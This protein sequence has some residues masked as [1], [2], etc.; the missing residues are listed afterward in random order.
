MSPPDLDDDMRIEIVTA[1]GA[2]PRLS[3]ALGVWTTRNRFV[4]IGDHPGA[5]PKGWRPRRGAV[6]R[7]NCFDRV[8][9]QASSLLDVNRRSV[10]SFSG[11]SPRAEE[12]RTR[13]YKGSRRDP[14]EFHN[15]PYGNQELHAKGGAR[16][17]LGAPTR[18]TKSVPVL[19]K[20]A[21]CRA[22]GSYAICC[23]HNTGSWSSTA[24]LDIKEG[25]LSL[26]G[27][28]RKSSCAHLSKKALQDFD[29][30]ADKE[31][32]IR[33]ID[34]GDDKDGRRQDVDQRASYNA[35]SISHCPT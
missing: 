23:T 7:R 33:P 6:W 16:L 24:T 29:Q 26:G 1:I 14:R 22:S 25:E 15:I 34:V 3:N 28:N 13:C 12:D 21:C 17:R 11:E 31:R 10:S 35:L 4:A 18:K 8:I 9:Q 2:E 32:F 27:R 30:A 20:A 19:P 5:L